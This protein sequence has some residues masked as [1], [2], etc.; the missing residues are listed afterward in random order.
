MIKK[1]ILNQIKASSPTAKQIVE[2]LW[3]KDNTLKAEFGKPN[4]LIS[5]AGDGFCIDGTRFLSLAKSRENYLVVAP[6]GKGKSQVSVFPFL[7][8]AKAKSSLIINDPSGELSASI[9]YLESV[10]YKCNILDFAKKTGM[11]FNPLDGCA[12]NNLTQMR[13]VAKT[14]LSS[15]TKD[16]EDFFS[17]S[18]EDCLVLFIQFLMESEP[19]QFRNLANV[20]RLILEY[21]ASPHLIENLITTKGSEEVFRKFRAL[22]GAS[23][24]TRKSIVASALTALSFIG[25]DPTLCDITSRTTIRFEEFR[26]KPNALFVH[27]PIGDVKFYSAI[28]SLFFQEFYRFAF[29]YL[30][31]DRELDICMVMDEFDTLTAIQGYSEIISNARKFKIPQQ[32]ILQ[33]EALLSKYG[34]KAK[35]ILNNCNVKCYYGGLGQEAYDLERV[36]GNFEYKDGKSESIRQRPLMTASEIREMKDEILVIPS[37]EKP[38]KV[39]IT[40]AYK[41]KL[42]VAKLNTRPKSKPQPVQYNVSYIDLSIYR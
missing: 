41:Q 8:N 23:E 33:S 7:L 3:G 10:G 6:S 37:G 22:A 26:T 40:P 24:N 32:L 42:L 17:I 30:P 36:L 21:Q 5:T 1:L 38:L 27:V 39:P 29:S 13:K 9:P 20:Y 12:N 2:T 19:V 35:N 34:D 31:S 16:T 4:N 25:E 28:V 11:Y 15:T 18:A 14:L